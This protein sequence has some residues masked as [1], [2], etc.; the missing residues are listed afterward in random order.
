MATGS[1]PDRIPAARAQFPTTHWTLVMRVREG[2]GVRQAAL[3]ELCQLYWYPIYAFLRRQGHSRHDAEDLTQGFF[4]KLLHDRTLEAAEAGRGRLRT[5]LMASLERHLADQH[6]RKSALKRGGGRQIIAFDDLK[7][8]ERYAIEPKDLR[9]PAGV[10][11]FSHPGNSRGQAAP[12]RFHG[13]AG[14]RS[15]LG[16]ASCLDEPAVER[17]RRPDIAGGRARL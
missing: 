15:L 2:E 13:G 4:E 16:D 8:E 6:R 5:F 11:T 17:P 9:D 10:Q 3:E 12:R 7:A 14:A 1:D